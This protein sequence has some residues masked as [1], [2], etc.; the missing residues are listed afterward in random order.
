MSLVPSDPRVSSPA[1]D[2]SER[3]F[4]MAFVRLMRPDGTTLRDGEHD[5]V[6]YKVWG[7][8]QSPLKWGELWDSSTSGA[9]VPVP[10]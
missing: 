4:S 1:K 6:L 9:R 10:A 3:I 5:L 7:G 2:R 8:P